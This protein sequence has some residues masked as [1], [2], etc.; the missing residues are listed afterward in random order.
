ME[1]AC[2]AG[3]NEQLRSAAGEPYSTSC[4]EA[5]TGPEATCVELLHIVESMVRRRVSNLRKLDHPL[6]V[7]LRVFSF[8]A[9]ARVRAVCVSL[10]AWCARRTGPRRGSRACAGRYDER[11]LKPINT[12]MKDYARI[13]EIADDEWVVDP[14]DPR[15]ARETGICLS[16]GGMHAGVY[17]KHV[18]R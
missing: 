2:V 18:S 7:L 9:S 11:T 1:D 8:R 6:E 13:L 16:D 17:G 3:M 10:M 12:A 14:A 15:Y 5:L 4:F